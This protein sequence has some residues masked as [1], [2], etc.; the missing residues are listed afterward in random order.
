MEID[1]INI[2]MEEFMEEKKLF[3]VTTKTIVATGIGAAL[4]TLLF[5]YVKIPTGIPNTEIQTAYGVGAFFA[6]LFGPIAGGLIAF[7]GH[8]IS[9]SVQYGSAWWSWVIASGCSCFIM[10]LCYSKLD[11][12][13]GV[14]T[15]KDMLRFN[16]YQVIANV[17]SWM[18]IA[19]TLDVIIYAEPASLVFTQ[20]W[21]AALSNAV[22]AGVIGTLLLFVYSKTRAQKGSLTKEK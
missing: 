14:F 4:F 7:I 13:N 21:V 19:P 20:G 2:R 3:K 10:G 15:G 22:S 17:V 5:M 9:D 8:A 1:N 12:E 18:L 11:V 6:A 16:I